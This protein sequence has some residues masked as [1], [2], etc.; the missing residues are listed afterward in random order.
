MEAGIYSLVLNMSSFRSK[1]CVTKAGARL[2]VP[3]VRAPAGF[4]VLQAD[5]P[6]PGAGVGSYLA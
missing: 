3:E 1:V 2:Q 5:R 4:S 6:S